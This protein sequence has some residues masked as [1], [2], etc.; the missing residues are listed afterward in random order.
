MRSP[1]QIR[2]NEISLSPYLTRLRRSPYSWLILVGTLVGSIVS[3]C[4]PIY[5]LRAAYGEGGDPYTFHDVIPA[6]GRF[7][8]AN[9]APTDIRRAIYAYNHSWPY[10]DRV[11]AYAAALATRTPKS[12]ARMASLA[13]T[14]TYPRALICFTIWRCASIRTRP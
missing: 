5:V 14:L 8:L 10:V 6:M 13:A 1:A 9:G 7:L 3:G 2:L 12:M 11:L 4:S